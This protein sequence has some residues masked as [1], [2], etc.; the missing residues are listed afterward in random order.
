MLKIVSLFCIIIFSSILVVA[1]PERTV[2][3]SMPAIPAMRLLHHDYIDNNQ[4]L[5]YQL[6]GIND[7][8]FNVGKDQ[9]INEIL[10]DALTTVVNNMQAKVELNKNITESDKYQWLRGIN[11]MLTDFIS[12]YKSKNIKGALL[13]NIIKSYDAAMELQMKNESIKSLIEN[14]EMEVGELLIQNLCLKNN[15]SI[16]VSKEI[17]SLKKIKRFPNRTMSLL[18]QNPNAFYVDSIIL[19]IAY[20]SPEQLYNYAAAADSL[21]KK[22]QSINNPLVKK[23]GLL[24][25][26]KTGRMYFPFLDNL[27]QNKLS[28][29]SITR[30]LYDTVGY[31]QL[32]V[33]TQIEYVKRLSKNDTPLV[34]NLLTSKLQSKAIELFINEINSLHDEKSEKTRFRCLEKL[35]PQDLYYIIVLGEQE[36]YTSSY[37]GVYKRIFE[38]M[39]TPSADTL[40]AW[41]QGD[42]YKKFIKIAANY[43]TLD[44]FLNRV[45]KNNVEQLMRSFVSGLEKT[46]TLEDAVDI[47]NSYASIYNEKIKKIILQKI[48]ENLVEAEKTENQRGQIIYNLL[49]IIFESMDSSKHI[50]LLGRLGINEVY[51]MPIQVL[52][53]N[54]G[55]IVIQQ[56]FYGDKDGQGIFNSFF[57]NYPSTSWKK[58]DSEKWV[59]LRSIKGTPISI[60][61]NKPFDNEED[62]DSKAQEELGNYLLEQNLH[63]SIIIHRG[64][65]YFVN[66]T[67]EQL[68]NSAKVILLGSCGGYQRLNDVLETC[69]DAHIIASKQ[70]GAGLVNIALIVAITENLRIGKSLNWQT[71]WKNIEP[72]FKGATKE[73]FDDYVPPYKNLGAMFISAYKR[74]LQNN[75]P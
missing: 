33:K 32:L 35:S 66:N 62:L 18:A 44:D 40:L 30:L 37:L 55:R 27:Y 61:S 24:S 6:D 46:R 36:I 49:N 73:K 57:Q 26:M 4:K 58:I 43:N 5:I 7:S 10:N 71:I 11:E 17:L 45:D 41:M 31:Y 60:F 52:K 54:T 25:L 14:S 38:R 16:P 19:S 48:Q 28:M 42:Y 15:I 72:K 13:Y 47:A 70:T 39:K 1:Q 68:P 2:E 59:E 75:I 22:I 8:I 63:P 34:M 67:I 21:G 69:P 20:H 74:G 64:H 3:I 65:S 51:N 9:R 56:F 53:D 29:D 12:G 23:I 50:N